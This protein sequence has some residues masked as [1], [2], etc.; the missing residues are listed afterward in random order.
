MRP[1]GPRRDSSGGPRFFWVNL[2]DPE[3]SCRVSS[4]DGRALYLPCNRGNRESY[5]ADLRTAKGR[6]VAR[7]RSGPPPSEPYAA[8]IVGQY[9][10]V[11]LATENVAPTVSPPTPANRT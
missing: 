5:K 1:T 4:A 6:F 10:K 3:R 8:P 9:G 7:H 11:S 2:T